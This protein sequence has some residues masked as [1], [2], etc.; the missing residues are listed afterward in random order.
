MSLLNDYEPSPTRR[1]LA[2]LP[3]GSLRLQGPLP[4]R[5]YSSCSALQV[6]ENRVTLGPIFCN[7]P[8]TSAMAACSS[9]RMLQR[10]PRALGCGASSE[11][12]DTRRSGHSCP[13]QLLRASRLIAALT[14][15]AIALVTGA[16]GLISGEQGVG[17]ER[18]LAYITGFLVILLLGPGRSSLDHLLGLEEARPA[19]IPARA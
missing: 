16:N 11:L 13:R 6:G 1:A 17:Y 7:A 8:V 15:V 14:L 9:A 18:D 12:H 4:W 3:G 5:K 19:L 2:V 10:R